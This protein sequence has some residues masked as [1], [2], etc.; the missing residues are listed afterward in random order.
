MTTKARVTKMAQNLGINIQMADGRYPEIDMHA[1]AGFMFGNGC[2]AAYIECET[3]RELWADAFEDLQSLEP[4]TVTD[5][6]I[7]EAKED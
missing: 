5:C 3:M 6:E 2:H 4:C 1:P 7:C